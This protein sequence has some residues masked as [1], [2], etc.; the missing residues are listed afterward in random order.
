[1]DTNM[2]LKTWMADNEVTDQM[3][4]EAAG[5][6]RGYI[7]KIGHGWVNPT[8]ST[9]IRIWKFARKEFDLEQLLP[10]AERPSRKPT[11]SA[12]KKPI[13]QPLPQL[14]SVTGKSRKPAAPSASRSRASA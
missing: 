2:D 12:A 9:A 6:S 14:S 8:L 7:N 4:A 11:T 13:K 10:K 5:V 1:M 3:V